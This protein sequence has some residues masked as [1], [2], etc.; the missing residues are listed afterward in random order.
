MLGLHLGV[1]DVPYQY[2]KPTRMRHARK[3]SPRPKAQYTQS[4][5]DVARI[6]ESKYHVMGVYFRVHGRDVANF[7]ADDVV[8]ALKNV[9]AGQPIRIAQKSVLQEAMSKTEDSFRK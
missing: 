8:K 1:M 2:A 4:T 3:G 9:R 6:L 7:M 5:V